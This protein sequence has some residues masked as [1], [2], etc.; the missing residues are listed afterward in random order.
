MSNLEFYISIHRAENM[1]LSVDIAKS[2]TE[3]IDYVLENRIDE[4]FNTFFRGHSDWKFELVPSI[5]RTKYAEILKHEDEAIREFIASYPHFF[6][7][8]KS[9]LDYLAVLQH[10]GFPTRLLDITENPLVALYFACED[11]SGNHGDVIELSV[12]KNYYRYYDS[13]TVSILTNLSFMPHDFDVSNFDYSKYYGCFES[14]DKYTYNRYYEI[15]NLEDHIDCLNDFNKINSVD[16]LIH[17]IRTEKPFYRPIIDPQHMDNY[18][19]TVKAKNGF[20][21]MINQS[22]LFALFGIQ[23]KKSKVARFS[24]ENLEYKIKHIIIPSECKGNIIKQLNRLNINKAT[25][26][27][28]MDN[29]SKDF[30]SRY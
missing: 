26:Y 19:V 29:V 1:F 21:R 23:K 3:Y 28:D 12:N 15:V 24:F 11:Q 9:T 18:I 4:G 2:V 13:D 6:A 5:Y 20:N 10:H 27:C 16:K 8:C 22:G 25:I 14:N 30:I 17:K 7:E